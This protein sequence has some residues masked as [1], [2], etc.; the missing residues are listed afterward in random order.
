VNIIAGLFL[1]TCS[2]DLTIY[3]TVSELER[4]FGGTFLGNLQVYILHSESIRI[5]TSREL[6]YQRANIARFNQ[7][8]SIDGEHLKKIYDPSTCPCV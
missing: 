3:C 7:V 2:G 1:K 5:S 8:L 6:G 4:E